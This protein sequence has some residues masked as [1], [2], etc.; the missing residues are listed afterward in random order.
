MR[1]ACVTALQLHTCR[2]HVDELSSAHVYLRMPQGRA[3]DDIPPDTLEDCAQLVKA[4]S[5]QVSAGCPCCLLFGANFD[6][7]HG[8]GPGRI[9]FMSLLSRHAG[10]ALCIDARQSS[11]CSQCHQTTICHRMCSFQGNKIDNL[12]IVYTP[13]SNLKKTQSMEVGQVLPLLAHMQRRTPPY[14]PLYDTAPMGWLGVACN[15]YMTRE[16]N[17]WDGCCSRDGSS[18]ICEQHCW[19]V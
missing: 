13:V 12:G 1:N 18:C 10:S 5:I 7:H 4:N 19:F 6:R 11:P 2:F 9:R 14:P 17:E 16:V 3:W 8:R 15:G